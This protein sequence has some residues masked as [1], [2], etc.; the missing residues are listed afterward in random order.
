MNYILAIVLAIVVGGLTSVQSAI[1]TQLGKYVGGIGA[2]LISFIVGSA[3]LILF[4]LISGNG[5]LKN[6]GKAPLY[7]FI[8]G[9]FGAMFVFSMI[10]LI[11]KIGVSSSMAGVIAGQLLAAVAVDHFGFFGVTPIKFN[12][13][14]FIGSVFLLVGVKLMSK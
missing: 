2:A 10:K 12:Y 5:G 8:G 11:P 7:L 4:Y 6:S 14:R 13:V 3:T 1:N 9:V